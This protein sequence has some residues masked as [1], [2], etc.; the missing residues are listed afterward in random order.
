MLRWRLLLG[1]I[2]VAA[3]I[4]I[5]ALDQWAPVP[6][7]WLLPVAIA[8]TVLASQEMLGLAKAG[9]LRP[10]P[11]TIYGGNL[12]ILLSNWEQVLCGR[13]REPFALTD[14]PVLVLGVCLL[15]AFVG[16]IARY[17]QAG[18]VIA[19]LAVTVF[20]LLYVG[21]MM[22]FV[23][24]LRLVWG[25]GAL[26]SLLLPVKMGDIGAYT[27]GRL[28]GRHKLAPHLSPGKTIEGALGALVFGCVGSWICFTW[29]VPSTV[30]EAVKPGPAYGW[31]V[32]GLLMAVAG[33]VGDLAE[34]LLKRDVGVKDSSSW[35]PGFGGVLDMVDSVLLAAPLAWLWWSLGWVGK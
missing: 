31:L 17:R 30:T 35:L 12:L 24:Q 7:L 20:T 5:A 1:T 33:M 2:V 25:I 3:L 11:W 14:W 19:N 28:I 32:Y 27:V 16:E 26:A 4:G 22:S 21:L 18:G 15:V 8:F 6:G 13:G 34:S 29:L 10:L 23:V 9:R